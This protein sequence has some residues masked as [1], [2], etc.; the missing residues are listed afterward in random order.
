MQTSRKTYK[1]RDDRR[2]AHCQYWSAD[3]YVTAKGVIPAPSGVCLQNGIDRLP[4]D[5][6][7][8]DSFAKIE[9]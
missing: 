9:K 3:V 7:L 8:C 6:H 1:S 4:Y 2:C 5:N